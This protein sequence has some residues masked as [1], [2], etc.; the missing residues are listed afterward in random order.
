MVKEDILKHKG[1][2][3]VR[4]TKRWKMPLSDGWEPAGCTELYESQMMH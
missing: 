4:V 2:D 1:L 3:M